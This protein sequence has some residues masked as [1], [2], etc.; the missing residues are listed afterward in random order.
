MKFFITLLLA[1][2]CAFPQ[3]RD[4]WRSVRTNHLFVIGNAE[5]EKLRQ[6]AVWLEFFHRGFARVVSRNVIDS[7]V[8]TTVIVFRDDASFR[9]FK[10]LYQGRPANLAGFFQP[11]DDVNYIA[12]S[13]D[14]GDRD[15]FSTAFH[16]YVHLHV[17][18][19]IPGAPLWL[20]EGLAELYGSLQFSGGEALLGVPLPYARYLRQHELLPLTTLFSIGSNSEHYNEDDKTGIFYG[21]SWALVHYL[22]LGDR[23]RYDQFKSFL[24][25]IS[26][27]ETSAR[28][29][30]GAFGANLDVIEQ[31]FN[32]YVRRG[33][34]A[35]QRLGGVDDPQT[36]GYTAMQRTSL[37][38]GEA[39][40]YLGD[41]LLHIG[42]QADA[43]RYFKQAIA[44]EPGFVPA[45][46]ALGILSVHQ[47]RYADAKKY[48]EKAVAS[49]QNHLI[50]YF[51]AYVL[52]REGVS[53]AGKLS[54]YSRES[55]AV[56]REHLL[57]SIK[58]APSH[59]PSHYLLAVVNFVADERLDE[60]LEMVQRARQLAP[61]K[62]SYAILH[63]QI[64]MRR[65]DAAAARQILEPLTRDS[66]QSV[67]TEA[68]DLLESLSGTDGSNRSKPGSTPAVSSAMISEPEK[69]GSSRML[70][71]ES[72]SVAINDGRTIENSGSLPTVDEVLNKYV[73]AMG[74]AKAINAVTSRVT[75]GTV[76]LVG[77]SRGG[78]F[79]SYEL[80]PNKTLTVMQ[81]HPIGTI[82]LGF[83]GRSGWAHTVTGLRTLK[84]LEL[85]SVQR[86][87]DFYG[88]VRL[89]NNYPKLALAGKSRIGFRDVYVVDLQPAAGPVERLYLDAQTFLPVRMN[90]VKTNGNIS[91]PVEVYF[92]DWREIDGIK[93]PFNISES[94]PKLT[95]TIN[96]KEIRHNVAL[97]PT[98]FDPPK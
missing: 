10:P 23:N 65:S 13:L 21:E 40:Y 78:S 72:G 69:T 91:A 28:A 20:N 76:D 74:G 33:D 50:H 83:N 19:N 34:F 85:A 7:S 11:G 70:G 46:E 86:H 18:D 61:S 38:E 8:P 3:S 24:N 84:G 36:A 52:S 17:R 73:E 55:A 89:K 1:A 68:Q 44:I 15:P 67:R 80:A 26:Q 31:E 43:E 64:H 25:R 79:E 75:K 47:R 32:A 39:N 6:V 37:S 35:P 57:H 22:M 41:L 56:M 48:L 77:V 95:F 63:A 94:F 5:A 4:S 97:D 66:D 88:L 92:D 42:R 93:F 30:E 49:S 53:P 60:A 62:T 87:S 90:T 12:I 51:Y 96:I 58:L 29:L 59:A 16:E 82:K 81:A 27:G 9:P 98:V 71:G 54:T 45:N 2:V 14:P